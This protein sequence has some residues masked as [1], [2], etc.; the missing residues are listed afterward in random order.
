M[1][2]KKLEIYNLRHDYWDYAYVL[3]ILVLALVVY[4]HTSNLAA[5]V[6]LIFQY[7]KIK[8][9]IYLFKNR[10]RIATIYP[11]SI[12][13]LDQDFKF[14]DIKS[15][16]IKLC[17]EKK[18]LNQVEIKINKAVGTI[19]IGEFEFYKLTL[20]LR[21]YFKFHELNIIDSR[22]KLEKDLFQKFKSSM[23]MN[24]VGFICSIWIINSANNS[25]DRF[26][27]LTISTGTKARGFDMLMYKL[28]EYGGR[29]LVMQ[30]LTCISLI[31]FIWLIQS[32]VNFYS[33]KKYKLNNLT[34]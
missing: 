15:F 31:F 25:Y 23:Q 29:D 10:K 24:I 1:N 6:I 34:H 8:G 32:A 16:E 22:Q 17:E 21:S 30:V 12:R 2:P 20:K 26:V 9:I 7:L 33:L 4:Y 28:N 14:V 27:S 18:L 11:N 13:I 19:G 5:F 3:F